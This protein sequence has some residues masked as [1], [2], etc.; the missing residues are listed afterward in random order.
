MGKSKI[1]WT[2]YVW[3]PVTG[4]TPVSEGCRNCYAA[5]YAKR[6]AG[7]CGYPKDNPFRIILHLERLNEPL[8]WKKPRRVFVCSMGD[9]FHPDVPDEFIKQVFNSMATDIL[10]PCK[11]TYMVLTKRPERMLQFFEKYTTCGVAPWPNV[12][13]GV[14]AENQ[15]AADERIPILL[16]VPA[17]VHWV[18]CEPLLGSV[19]LSGWLE[20]T[21]ACPECGDMSGF[22]G[23]RCSCGEGVYVEQPRLNWVV[24]GG[25]TGPGAR[26]MHPDW[27]GSLRD[28]CQA[29]GVPFFF[30][31]WGE[32]QLMELN[33]PL[34]VRNKETGDFE[35]WPAGKTVF[36]RVSKKK[37]GRLL[38]GRTWDELPIHGGF[39]NEQ[40]G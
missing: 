25:E 22:V 33:E 17:A 35:T 9:L 21:W 38:D 5:R 16:Q 24:V 3:N 23:E 6:L 31:Q 39:K 12:W 11:H 15:E 18:S 2:D 29:A 27:V 7:R 32:W 26:P 13:L 19:D 8:R 40:A 1:E 10:Q 20:L 14:T 37:A 28:Q 34:D 36:K 4:C 30:K